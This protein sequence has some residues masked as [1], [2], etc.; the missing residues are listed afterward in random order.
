MGPLTTGGKSSMLPPRRRAE[1]MAGRALLFAL[2][3]FV[4]WLGSTAWGHAASVSQDS[5]SP[6][7]QWSN[8]PSPSANF[9]PIAVW[10]QSTNH[11]AE[12]KGIG[13]N[14][15]VGFWGDLDQ[16]SL[17]MFA[18]GRM[19][20]I[21]TQ[22]SVGLA[23]PQNRAVIGWIQ[24]DEPDN[25][26]HQ[27]IFGYRSCQTPSQISALYSAIKAK[28]TT[29][30]VVLNFGRGVSDTT[31][32]GRGS[33]TGQT[34]SY[35]P[36]AVMGG[37][38]I[39]F[40]IYPVA[41]YDGRLE[42]VPNGLDNLKSWIAMSGT[43]KIIWNAVEAVPISSG[44][45][46]TASQERAEVWM[47]LIHG[48]QGLIYFVHQFDAD[49]RKLIREDGI[50]NFPALAR[51]VASINA[52][53]AALAPVLNSPT[54][55]NGVGVVAPGTTPISTMVKRY[56]GSTYVFAVAMLDNAGRATF[57]LPDIPTGTVKVLDE[58]RQ[59]SLSGG[60]FEDDFTGYGVHLYQVTQ[61]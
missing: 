33:C 16:T 42:M 15:F 19:P 12:F 43:G 52:R 13:I 25:A 37:D 44:A 1:S 20:L 45:V 48:S 5:G 58:S 24:P 14:T 53:I 31:W 61:K 7:S 4:G 17:E 28:D 55:T 11:I 50:F 26:Q 3:C 8:G 27:G 21:P 41:G 18:R 2:W 30:P 9:F 35:Y 46:P 29:R 6:Y 47:S 57:T 38:I 23:A 49:G 40:D 56:N 22:N 39:S 32:T 59:L 60:V 54:I 10:L 36:L 34:T 51:A